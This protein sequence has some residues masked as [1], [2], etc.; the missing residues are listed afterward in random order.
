MYIAV[1]VSIS[2]APLPWYHSHLLPRLAVDFCSCFTNTLGLRSQLLTQWV[3][4]AILLEHKADY[5][6]LLFHIFH[7][8][9][10]TWEG[11]LSPDY[12]LQ[13]TAESGPCPPLQPYSFAFFSLLL[14]LSH[15]SLP[16]VL[17][18]MNSG[19][20]SGPLHLLPSPLIMPFSADNCMVFIFPSFELLSYSPSFFLYNLHTPSGKNSTSWGMLVKKNSV[21]GNICLIP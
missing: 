2:L 20:A 8:F 10:P 13:S 19:P 11:T 21:T 14:C 3:E 6:A 17:G 16:A 18:E 15:T 7:G 1:Y 4:Q 5:I 9:L 12:D